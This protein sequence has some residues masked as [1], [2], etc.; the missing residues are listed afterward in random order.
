ME[1]N[2]HWRECM[3]S[4]TNSTLEIPAHCLVRNKSIMYVYCHRITGGMCTAIHFLSPTPLPGKGQEKGD[5]LIA[6]QH[7]H[8]SLF[9]KPSISRG[10][11]M[12]GGVKRPGQRRTRSLLLSRCH[13]GGLSWRYWH[14]QWAGHW[15]A[16]YWGASFQKERS[17]PK[18]EPFTSIQC[19]KVLWYPAI[20]SFRRGNAWLLAVGIEFPDLEMVKIESAHSVLIEDSLITRLNERRSS[21]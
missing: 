4:Q 15:G 17:G 11:R 12:R 1:A 6:E 3:Q 21:N 10:G 14:R 19:L 16:D 9:G 7:E 13:H 8:L 20:L 5:A 2:F 18:W